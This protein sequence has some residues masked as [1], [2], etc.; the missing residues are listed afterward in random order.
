MLWDHADATARRKPAPEHQE[1][2]MV[3]EEGAGAA[4]KADEDGALADAPPSARAVEERE[5]EVY[6]Y[7]CASIGA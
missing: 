6:V 7:V 5:A 3:E 4:R 1:Y 2:D